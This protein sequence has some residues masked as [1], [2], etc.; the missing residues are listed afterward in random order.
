MGIVTEIPQWFTWLFAVWMFLFNI[1]FAMQLVK[2]MRA[3]YNDV[4]WAF[5]KKHIK[6][7]KLKPPNWMKFT[8]KLSVPRGTLKHEETQ[9]FMHDHYGECKS[10]KGKSTYLVDGLCVG[11]RRE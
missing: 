10:C 7:P 1:W 11:C 3:W 5:I 2:M 4:D 8:W 6:R 9:Y